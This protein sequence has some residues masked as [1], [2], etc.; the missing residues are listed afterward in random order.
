MPTAVTW[1]PTAK[2]DESPSLAVVRPEAF[3]SRRSAMSSAGSIPPRLAAYVV[4]PATRTVM[5]PAASMT[6]ALVSTSPEGV[7]TIPVPTPM[8]PPPRSAVTRTTAAAMLPVPPVP[9]RPTARPM[10]ATA[11]TTRTPLTMKP[12]RFTWQLCAAAGGVLGGS[13]TG[14]SIQTSRSTR[15]F[16]VA[17]GGKGA[18]SV[19]HDRAPPSHPACAARTPGRRGRRRGRGPDRLGDPGTA[20]GRGAAVA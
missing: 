6:C 9:A 14:R 8:R 11:P 15:S 17:F 1:S 2:A 18:L 20:A 7:T 4:P 10:S 16:A 12:R 3:G 5:R 13:V 19:P